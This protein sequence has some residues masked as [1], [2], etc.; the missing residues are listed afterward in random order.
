MENSRFKGAVFGGFN[1]GDVIRYI[2]KTA[3]ESSDAVAALEERNGMLAGENDGLRGNVNEL[4]LARDTLAG[5]LADVQAERDA[6]QAALAAEKAQCGALRAELTA[7]QEALA[8]L[9]AEL[10]EVQESLAQY[11]AEAEEYGAVKKHIA[12]IELT[13]RQRAEA[14]EAKTRGELA[15]RIGA[16]RAQCERTMQTLGTT[17]MN[18]SSELRKADAAVAQLPTAFGTLRSELKELEKLK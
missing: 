2:E 11:R 6:A 13:A 17:C 9:R 7:A 15:E 4:T 14:L 5:Q 16:V 8:R 12:D 1:R 3:Q 18:V 10:G